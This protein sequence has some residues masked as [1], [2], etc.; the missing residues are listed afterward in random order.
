MTDTDISSIT[1]EQELEDALS[2]PYS[3]DIEF[4]EELEGDV[5]VL[6]AAGKMGP[7]LVRRILRA[8]ERAGTDR[9]VYA[10]SRYSDPAVRAALDDIDGCETIQADLLEEG[11]LASLPDCRNVIYMV[12]MK[13]GT[14]GREPQTWAINSYLP[15]EVARRFDDSRIVAF[16]TGN[17][18]PPVPVDSGGPTETDDTGP[19]GEYAQSC[20]GRERV[21]Q[22]FAERN[23]TPTC[24][25]RL[26][27]SVEARYGVLVDIANWVYEGESVPL[28]TGYVNVIWQG[29]ANSA[30]F[31]SLELTDSPAETLNVTGPETLSVRTVAEQ[32]A[33]RFGRQVTFEAEE[34]ETALLSDASRATEIFGEPKVPT[35]AVVDLVASWIRQGNPTMDKPTKFHV[36]SGEF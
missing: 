22:Y 30:C 20:L 3:E 4:A 13:F 2:E 21:F 12:G 14:S 33:D 23:D 34:H 26:N 18:Y 6:G 25:F 17:V 32:F 10:V 5:M 27:Y 7:S 31:R 35:E 36:R 19:V 8:S 9:T 15:G 29:D 1:T 28:A 16:S 11:S 24:L